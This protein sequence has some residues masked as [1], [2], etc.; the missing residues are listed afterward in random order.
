MKY[1][2]KYEKC[3]DK[4]ESER[5]VLSHTS[6][7][8][9][10]GGYIRDMILDRPWKDIDLFHCVHPDAIE[11]YSSGARFDLFWYKDGKGTRTRWTAVSKAEYESDFCVMQCEVL[12]GVQLILFSKGY[13]KL[14]NNYG[15]CLNYMSHRFP[16]TL[17]MAAMDLE[18]APAG[19]W[20]Y[21]SDAFEG[22]LRE[23]TRAIMMTQEHSKA[24]L[25]EKLLNLEYQLRN[26]EKE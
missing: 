10:M 19:R 26:K 12:P 7:A 3:K 20:F 15:M 21:L 4:Y 8:V 11:A 16:C 22:A 23:H 24:T 25:A 18:V 1:K 9:L 5:F 2:D 14:E 17:S 13:H 6:P